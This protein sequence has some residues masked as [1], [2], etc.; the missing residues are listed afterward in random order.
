VI[1]AYN[2]CR[3]QSYI[4][5]SIVDYNL[6]KEGKIQLIGALKDIR[7]LIFDVKSLFLEEC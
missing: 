5:G 6:I 1:Y 2:N 7:E 4:V 3:I